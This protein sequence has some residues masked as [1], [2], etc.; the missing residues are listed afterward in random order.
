MRTTASLADGLLALENKTDYQNISFVTIRSKSEITK[1][2][3]TDLGI[4]RKNVNQLMEAHSEIETEVGLLFDEGNQSAWKGG[5][6]PCH[7]ARKRL[8]VQQQ[9]LSPKGRKGL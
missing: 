6:A 9:N 8:A 5:S 7:C 4:F 2:F 1:V 3:A